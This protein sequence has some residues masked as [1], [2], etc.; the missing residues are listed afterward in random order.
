MA[1]LEQTPPRRGT[2]PR[3]Q[4]RTNRR[5]ER[6]ERR[7]NE[8]KV[9]ELLVKLTGFPPPGKPGTAWLDTSVTVSSP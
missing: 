8:Q 7:D 1:N 2:Q 5:I 3:T 9:E 6:L 4:A